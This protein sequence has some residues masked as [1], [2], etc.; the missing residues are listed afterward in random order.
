MKKEDIGIII[1]AL[2]FVAVAVSSV[3]SYQMG[4]QK[5]VDYQKEQPFEITIDTYQN[6]GT[7]HYSTVFN[8]TNEGFVALW[9]DYVPDFTFYKIMKYKGV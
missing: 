5:G 9:P 7:D 2:A 4:F 1:L 6:N 8:V 3:I